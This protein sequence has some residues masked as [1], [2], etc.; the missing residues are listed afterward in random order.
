MKLKECFE[1]ADWGYVIQASIVNLLHDPEI[2]R[3]RRAV[4]KVDTGFAGPIM[5]TSDIFELLRFSDTEVPD[6][7]RSSYV[8]LAGAVSVRS[9]PAVLEIGGKEIE[10]DILTPLVGPS[11]MLVGFQLLRRL[12]LALLRNRACF[13]AISEK[14]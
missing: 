3:E 12:N 9:A 4:F 2:P 13:L 14:D 8:A 1:S 7:M 10:T 11:R 5:V 6:D